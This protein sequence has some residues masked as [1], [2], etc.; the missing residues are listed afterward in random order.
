MVREKKTTEE[1][2]TRDAACH[3]GIE[4]KIREHKIAHE[5]RR[6]DKTIVTAIRPASIRD[7]K[8]RDD[9]IRYVRSLGATRREQAKQGDKRRRATRSCPKRRHG[10]RWP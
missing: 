5:K 7:D 4:G 6:E 2:R 1:T 3:Q 9:D 10:R 8:K